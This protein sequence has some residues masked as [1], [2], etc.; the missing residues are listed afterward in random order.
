MQLEQL[1]MVVNL[2]NYIQLSSADPLK[3]NNA[4][5]REY[6]ELFPKLMWVLRDFTLKMQD[7]SGAQISA[8]QY[9]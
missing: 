8:E 4:K 3:R 2:T 7:K 6:S 5:P 9:L 1:S